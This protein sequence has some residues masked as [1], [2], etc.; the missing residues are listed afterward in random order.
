LFD[1][2]ADPTD[3]DPQVCQA[4]GYDAHGHPLCPH[5]FKLTWQGL[6]RRAQPRA[7][8][9]C[10]HLCGQSPQGPVAECPWLAKKRGFHF[11]LTRHFRDGSSR[12]ARLVPYDTP[13][14][15]KYTGWRNVS[16]GRNSVM[17]RLGLK[18][19]PDYGLGHAAFLITG[20]DVVE[21]WSTLARLVF[22]ATA[23]DEGFVLREEQEPWPRPADELGAT[24]ATG[25]QLV[26]EESTRA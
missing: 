10:G 14:W 23:Q 3:H 7:R 21:N 24:G 1:V 26:K 11:Y 13:L 25:E 5:G 9:V 19:L 20:A 6:E 2:Q 18:R 15:R 16:E 22:E 4:R 12:L 8:W 17:V